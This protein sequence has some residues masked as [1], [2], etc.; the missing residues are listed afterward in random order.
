MFLTAALGTDGRPIP[1]EDSVSG[2]VTCDL[3]ARADNKVTVSHGRLR[4]WFVVPHEGNCTPRKAFG[5][6]LLGGT[7]QVAVDCPA[8][9]YA[10]VRVVTR[11]IAG[12]FK[13]LDDAMAYLS[14][15]LDIAV[16]LPEQLPEEIRLAPRRPVTVTTR[17]GLRS[18]RLELRF[19]K[20]G[21][22]TFD[23]GRASFDGCGGD[24]AEQVDI[25]GEAGL[26]LAKDEYPWTQIIWPAEPGDAEAT[27]GIYGSLQAAEMLELARSMP[28]VAAAP[29]EKSEGCL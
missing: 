27:Y 16:A 22:L 17:D 14:D 3:V 29:I 11:R 2:Q 19:A 13:S 20:N 8:C 7:Y 5:V 18:G 21:I 26:M 1:K 12:S 6:P 24:G 28:L 15:R 23:F 10:T 4:G 9:T 25:N